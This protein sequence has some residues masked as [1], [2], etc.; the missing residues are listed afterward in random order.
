MMLNGGSGGGFGS[1]EGS[2]ADDLQ[3]FSRSMHRSPQLGERFRDV[4]VAVGSRSGSND[5]D[6]HKRAILLEFDA[7]EAAEQREKK[8]RQDRRSHP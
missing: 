8:R 5:S 3:L 6:G 4:A 1:N 7:L 2:V